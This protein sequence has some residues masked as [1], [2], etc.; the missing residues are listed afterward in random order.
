[1]RK[2]LFFL[3]ISLSFELAA[4]DEE[5]TF[6]EGFPDVPLVAGVRGV[7]GESVLFD[8]PSGT[9]AEV[10]LLIEGGAEH[11]FA[12]YKQTLAAFGWACETKPQ[13]LICLREKNRLVFFDTDPRRKN[14]TIIL[15]LEPI[16]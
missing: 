16:K 4:Q 8:T 12:A 5:Q 1:M 15:R 14:G 2:I 13:T 3:L 9:I 7:D 6:L 10:K 11:V